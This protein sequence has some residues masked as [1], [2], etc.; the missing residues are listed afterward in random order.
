MPCLPGLACFI[1]SEV[2]LDR[3][4]RERAE[5]KQAGEPYCVYPVWRLP[6]FEEAMCPDQMHDQVRPAHLVAGDEVAYPPLAR[7]A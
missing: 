3:R 1:G 2:A 4:G 6:T 5:F 7:S